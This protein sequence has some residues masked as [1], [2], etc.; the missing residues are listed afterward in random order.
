MPKEA[1]S[2][3]MFLDLIESKGFSPILVMGTSYKILLY[4]PLG[5]NELSTG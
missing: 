1:S 3:L 5:V 2:S 4:R